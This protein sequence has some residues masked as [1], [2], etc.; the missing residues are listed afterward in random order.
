MIF[1]TS[2]PCLKE[3]KEPRLKE[4]KRRKGTHADVATG[5]FDTKAKDLEAETRRFCKEMQ[6][7]AKKKKKLQFSY[8]ANRY[9][10]CTNQLASS[11]HDLEF[12]VHRYHMNKISIIG[13][14]E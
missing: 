13:P 14:F 6:D 7:E 12:Q 11:R 8:P 3:A 9:H 1:R 10:V 4:W 5:R 2:W